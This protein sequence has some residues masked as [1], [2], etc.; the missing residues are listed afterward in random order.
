MVVQSSSAPAP[1]LRFATMCASPSEA[2]VRTQRGASD[3]SASSPATAHRV[4]GS[5][6]RNLSFTTVRPLGRRRPPLRPQLSL[7]SRV[8]L[9]SFRLW[10]FGRWKG[11]Q[12]KTGLLSI[13][14]TD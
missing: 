2:A 13:L 3:T 12:M 11:V 8:G 4:D 5:F 9:L 10:G 7:D 6:L 14:R 1:L